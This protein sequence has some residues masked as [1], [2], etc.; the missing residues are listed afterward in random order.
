MGRKTKIAKETNKAKQNKKRQKYAIVCGLLS[1]TV[2]GLVVSLSSSSKS[3]VI[4]KPS[5]SPNPLS[6]PIPRHT[7][8]AQVV[9]EAQNIPSTPDEKT[10][11]NC[12]IK[13]STMTSLV[14][15]NAEKVVSKETNIFGS[16]MAQ[17]YQYQVVIAN[18]YDIK[19]I[20]VQGINEN[21]IVFNDVDYFLKTGVNKLPEQG[22]ITRFN[23]SK[24]VKI[25]IPKD[26]TIY[27]YDSP[28]TGKDFC[29]SMATP[30]G[31]LILKSTLTKPNFFLGTA[32]SPTSLT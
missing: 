19:A 7:T 29:I 31:K 15:K 28:R 14:C 1:I 9:M 25:A 8:P 11:F 20:L 3:H 5:S 24:K 32:C 21:T 17:K 26:V 6:L 12:L 16:N 27:V 30:D 2:I 18:V 4:P 23:G 13:P 22:T 10:Y